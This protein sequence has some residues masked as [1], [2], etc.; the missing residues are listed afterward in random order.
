M[1]VLIHFK[2]KSVKEYWSDSNY[3]HNKVVLDIDT[4]KYDTKEDVELFADWHIM[5][6]MALLYPIK[7]G[8]GFDVCYEYSITKINMNPY[9]KKINK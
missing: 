6:I 5:D 4:I 8:S 1:K 3:T 2:H 9:N 7:H